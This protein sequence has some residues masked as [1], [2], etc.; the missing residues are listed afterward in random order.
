MASSNDVA[1]R[2]WVLWSN[3]AFLAPWGYLVYITAKTNDGRR[4][5]NIILTLA[6]GV[7]SFL[8]HLCDTQDSPGDD[9]VFHVCILPFNQLYGG[10]FTLSMVTL[11]Q[12]LS[13]Q[14]PRNHYWIRDCSIIL[15]FIFCIYINQSNLALYIFMG[16][17]AFLVLLAR[18]TLRALKSDAICCQYPYVQDGRVIW[19]FPC[20]GFYPYLIVA[21]VFAAAGLVAYCLDDQFYYWDLH[22]TWH[23]C[24]AIGLLFLF[25]WIDTFP[26]ETEM[27]T[28]SSVNLTTTSTKRGRARKNKSIEMTST[29]L[30]RNDGNSFIV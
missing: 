26:L 7:A 17:M 25:M 20:E 13:Y 14:P 8:Y 6:V 30:T 22:P 11:I 16:I 10:D 12:A 28:Y 18:W 24:E 9:G 19:W 27:I 1:T 23:F 15:T 2:A 5:V 3:A 4:G 21:L 29:S